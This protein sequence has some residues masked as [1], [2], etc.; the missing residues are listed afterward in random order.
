MNR[1]ANI[2]GATDHA[3]PH[4][5]RGG[6]PNAAPITSD[7]FDTE[8]RRPQPLEP[9][10]RDGGLEP[11]DNQVAPVSVGGR[12]SERGSVTDADARLSPAPSISATSPVLAT[13]SPD[14]EAGRADDLRTYSRC[15]DCDGPFSYRIRDD[16]TRCAYPVDDGEHY[17]DQCDSLWTDEYLAGSLAPGWERVEL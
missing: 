7:P 17:C 8:G 14:A 10:A 4:P 6:A 12:Q 13:H 11:T 5:R 1:P 2:T 16:D 9:W 3:V 15:P